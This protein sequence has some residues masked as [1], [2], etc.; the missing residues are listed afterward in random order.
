MPKLT[1]AQKDKV[2]LYFSGP[3]DNTG[4]RLMEALGIKGGKE[5]PKGKKGV[6][7]GYGAKTSKNM[8]VNAD[9]VINHPNAIRKNRN[10]FTA[11][12]LMQTA[13]VPV[14]TFVNAD[15]V[16]K[17]LDN[18]KSGIILPLVGRTNYHQG[19]K[20]FWTCLTR[21]QV[22]KAI[23]EGAQYFQNYVDMANEYRL[24]VMNGKVIYAQR[25]TEQ[26]DPAAGFVAAHTEKIQG[27]AEKNN[28]KLDGDTMA[29]VLGNLSK[30]L[31]ATPNH[32]VKSNDKGWLFSKVALGNVKKELAD[33][34][35][36]AAKAIGLEFSAV[37]CAI[38]D[39]GTVWIIETNTGPGLKKSSF[40][41][42]VVEFNA[43]LED[44]FK[45]AVVPL[46]PAKA[47]GKGP[48]KAAVKAAPKGAAKKA[49]GNIGA[50]DDGQKLE[51]MEQMQATMAQMQETMAAL[52][53]K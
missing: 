6:V 35:I 10:K 14:A 42:Y 51:I 48:K 33:A 17:A 4:T 50:M 46:K 20:G 44:H 36:A 43:I 18:E 38:S 25:K 13:K 34:A 8:N 26:K 53:A 1:K 9:L 7:I 47:A 45:P 31:C 22:K 3:T 19:G 16:D 40:D 52:V 37:D 15:G 27:I 49:V 39:D 29:Y 12:G 32:I 11:L 41:A 28:A 5:A 21:G 30:K 2:Y 23:Q 24:H